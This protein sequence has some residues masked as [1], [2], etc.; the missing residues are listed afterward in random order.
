MSL[1]NCKVKINFGIYITENAHIVRKFYNKKHP[2]FTGSYTVQNYIGKHME[3]LDEQTGIL[4][5]S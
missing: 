5:H 3:D 1:Y 4:T 2:S